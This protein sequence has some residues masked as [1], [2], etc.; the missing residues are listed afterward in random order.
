MIMMMHTTSNI[1]AECEYDLANLTVGI[2]CPPYFF[3]FLF[4]SLAACCYDT[5]DSEWHQASVV[6]PNFLR[7]HLPLTLSSLKIRCAHRT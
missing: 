2:V 1:S 7:L 4:F 5:A 6:C 3:F